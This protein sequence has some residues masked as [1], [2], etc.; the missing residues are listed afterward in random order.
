VAGLRET[1][2]D[3]DSGDESAE[4]ALSEAATRAASPP[5]APVLS[6]RGLGAYRGYAELLGQLDRLRRRGY[7]L[8][9]IGKSVRGEPLFALHLGKEPRGAL[10]RTAVVLSGVHPTEWIGVETT[11]RL[12]DALLGED[13]GERSVVAIP[14]VNPDGFRR[15]EQD[16][17]LGRR[18]FVRHNARGVDLNRNFDAH[19][20][21]L[22][23]VQR[24][25]RRTFSP[26][27]RPASEP[28]V[29]GVA[30]H[31]SSCRVDR[32]LSLHSFGGAVLHPSA[33]TTR[34]VHDQEEHSAWA[35]R[36]A[37]AIDP[38]RPYRAKSCS[39]APFARATPMN[40]IACGCVSKWRA[41]ASCSRRLRT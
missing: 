1:D 40:R 15:V 31:L 25:L 30:H 35:H 4:L 34:R 17:R 38:K 12:L 18:R 36:I 13:L 14:I 6:A 7:R 10:T 5:L 2:T 22:G 26:G 3:S 28:E 29:F 41:C 21:E 19:W 16:L 37:R 11:L 39:P 9:T 32:A 8:R 27:T 33:A 24:I 20:G 23:L